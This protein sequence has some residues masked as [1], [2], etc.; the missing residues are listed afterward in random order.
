[1]ARGKKAKQ[2]GKAVLLV[3]EIFIVVILIGLLIV[4]GKDSLF[5]NSKED[6]GG[7]GPLISVDFD[8][9][10]L[11]ITVPTEEENN[12]MLG[13]RNI[14]LFGVDTRDADPKSLVKGTLSD[15]IMIASINEDTGEIKIVSVYRDTYL[16]L[17]STS[18]PNKYGKC[19]SAYS[20][21]GAEQAI[22]MLN[23]NLGL[24]I[25]EFVTVGFA[26]LTQA[27]DALGGIYLDV[28]NEEIKHINSYQQTMAEDLNMKWTPVEETGYQLLNGLQAT[29]YCRIR[30]RKGNDF[31]RAEAQREVLQALVDKAKTEDIGT[32]TKA[33]EKVSEHVYTSFDTDDILDLLPNITKYKIVEE[34]GFPNEAMRGSGTLGTKSYV[35]TV[36]LVDNVM[37]LHEFLFDDADYVPSE[38]VLSNSETIHN[39]VSQYVDID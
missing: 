19:N 22:R 28:D 7:K 1:M 23:E 2:Q 21:G 25:T 26:G 27:V 15:S 20:Y 31:A 24:D 6:E 11:S 13:Y 33:V 9:S 3:V 8:E 32:L 30:Y 17:A 38:T 18:D 14:A 35:Y 4:F 5:G 39:F 37:W 29:A 36:D 34:G 16:N 12:H 10:N